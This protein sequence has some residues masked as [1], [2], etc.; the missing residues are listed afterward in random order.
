MP[1]ETM[2]LFCAMRRGGSEDDGGGEPF[3]VRVERGDSVDDLKKAVKRQ[4]ENDLRGM[5]A[6]RLQLFLAKPSGSAAWLTKRALDAEVLRARHP[7]RAYVEMDAALWRNNAKYFGKRF[8]PKVGDIHVL[9]VA[10]RDEEAGNVDGE[11]ANSADNDESRGRN[12]LKRWRELNKGL[13]GHKRAR[14][15]AGGEVGD[16]EANSA[17]EYA[18]VRWSDVEHFV[19]VETYAQ[20]PGEMDR[21]QTDALYKR[22][23]AE[24]DA[25]GGLDGLMWKRRRCVQLMLES[26]RDVFDDDDA[27]LSEGMTVVGEK[28]HARAFLDCVLQHGKARVGVVVASHGSFEHGYAQYFVAADALVED[29][30]EEDDGPLLGVVTNFTEWHLLRRSAR[31]PFTIACDLSSLQ[32]S[33]GVPTY[34]SVKVVAEKL[35]QVPR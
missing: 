10:L 1:A 33:R 31:D 7:S 3:S 18:F 12:R 9:V 30:D 19:N 16:G 29:A 35:Y 11:R 8:S 20:T 21:E 28:V 24:I 32:L 26:V 22:L 2:R 27:Q 4:K 25:M 23:C 15:S 34:Y 6:D 17:S 13:D 5:D 14:R